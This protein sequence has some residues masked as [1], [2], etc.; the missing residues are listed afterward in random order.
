MNRP[1]NMPIAP[2]ADIKHKIAWRKCRY[3]EMHEPVRLIS[4]HN[5]WR[6]TG[7]AFN[8]WAVLKARPVTTIGQILKDAE[9]IGYYRAAA[10]QHLK[11]L[12]TWGDFLEI[13]GQRYFPEMEIEEEMPKRRQ[14]S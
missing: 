14:K 10:M 1:L 2:S 9:A 8:M 13:S 7:F 12:Y 5:P 6:P 3:F 11:W 4:S